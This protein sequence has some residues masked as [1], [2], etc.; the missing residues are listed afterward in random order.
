[1]PGAALTAA[2]ALADGGPNE[3]GPGCVLAA[4]GRWT[5]PCRQVE[6]T[7]VEQI[8]VRSDDGPS[9]LP[10]RRRS[11]QARADRRS[12]REGHHV[13][14][15]VCDQR[16]GC[17]AGRL[18]RAQCA[19]P[20]PL[21]D[22]ASIAGLLRRH[23]F[24]GRCERSADVTNRLIDIGILEAAAPLR[25]APHYSRSG[26]SRPSH[27]SHDTSGRRELRIELGIPV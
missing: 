21:V 24:G 7:R 22:L 9:T 5:G 26:T 3:P 27:E 10:V 1:M 17:L 11:Q 23:D 4:Y 19:G 25:M 14:P 12:A 20:Q 13:G 8:A 15:R 16:V 18:V 6:S 2:T